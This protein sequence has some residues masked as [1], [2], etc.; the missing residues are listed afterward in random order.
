MVPGQYPIH[1]F[2][3]DTLEEAVQRD[4]SLAHE[5]DVERLYAHGRLI[6]VVDMREF[7]FDVR[8]RA[9]E[10]IPLADGIPTTDFTNGALLVRYS[11]GTWSSDTAQAYVRVFTD[12][13]THDEPQTLFVTSSPIAEVAMS[14]ATAAPSLLVAALQA[15]IGASVRV[16][17]RWDQGPTESPDPESL[18]VGVDILGRT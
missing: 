5:L 18:V 14:N 13:R 3:P 12:S 15:P 10:D 6:P 1:L 7:V 9:L 16:V 11:K 8:D 4:G 2:P 17:L